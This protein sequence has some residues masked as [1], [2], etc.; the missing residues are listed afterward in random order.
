[1]ALINPALA[2]P[3]LA[4]L[5]WDQ[6]NPVATWVLILAILMLAATISRISF[7]YRDLRNARLRA[8][9]ANAL[10]SASMEAALDCV[11]TIDA[12]SVVHEWNE[13][14]RETF[15]YPRDE[16]IGRDMAD[17]IV[18]RELRA[19]H[20]RGLEAL[21][22]TG[23]SPV[24]NKRIEVMA[25]HARGGSFPVEL[26]ITRI[27]EDPPMFTAFVRDISERKR[28]QEENE[29]LAAIV[30]S[31]EDAIYSTDLNGA[32][33]AWNHGAE[34]LYG[35]SAVE[36]IGTRLVDLIIPPDK[37]GEFGEIA[38]KVIAGDSAAIVTK[39]QTK[40]GQQLDASLRA[41]P[42]RDLSG[43]IIG[44]S[45]SAHDITERRR[46]EEQERG[47]RE[48]R[49]WRRRIQE[50]LA[51]D[52]F[53][54]FGQPVVDVAT[55]ELQYHELLLRMNLDG[56][57][58]TPNEFLPHAESSDLITEI[59]SWVIS[60]GVEL[61]RLSPVAINLSAKSLST[62]DLIETIQESMRVSG[63]SPGN[64][65]FEITET[66]AATNLGAAHSRVEELVALGF[67]VALDDFGTGYGSF[68]YL[69]HLPVTELK[70]DILFIRNLVGNEVDRRVVK[71]IISV[72]ENF[73]MTTVAEGVEDEETSILLRDM[74]VDL[75]QGYHLGRPTPTSLIPSFDGTADVVTAA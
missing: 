43:R 27:Q 58:V 70:I 28:R 16:A 49:R 20:R 7:L 21:R 41:F 68:T 23:T 52:D 50:A 61:G 44:L 13:A 8:E 51:H 12:E 2:A 25:A 45:F 74:G 22:T 60:H 35:Y 36:A 3:A 34:Q 4:V 67:G 59:D 56:K 69:K 54:F 37:V 53:V 32:V 18:P 11:I 64:V 15:G 6:Y 38:N 47:D 66:A 42:I 5:I 63:T 1:M 55:R 71:S 65:M 33:M 26:T 24:L 40:L 14:A 73:G 29:R 17:L 48:R 75:L 31:S 19:R 30:R 57:V 72:A 46:R 10:R 9:A 39:R 62:A